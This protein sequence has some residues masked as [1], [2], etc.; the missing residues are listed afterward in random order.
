MN[1]SP[2]EAECY[3]ES[4]IYGYYDNRNS[5]GTPSIITFLL[6]STI[7][8]VPCHYT[9]VRALVF[10]KL[11]MTVHIDFAVIQIIST[12]V[13]EITALLKTVAI[14]RVIPIVTILIAYRQSNQTKQE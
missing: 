9:T 1:V 4:K 3:D 10:Y 14:A 13:I 7:M 2:I 8:T 6:R 11:A 5:L 12:S